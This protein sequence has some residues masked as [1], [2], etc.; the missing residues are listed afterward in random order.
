MIKAI[1]TKEEEHIAAIPEGEKE[2]VRQIF[3]NKGFSGETL[4]KIVDVITSD[5]ALWVDTMLQDEYGV[6]TAT[7]S[8]F[9]SG[10][11]TFVA[12]IAIGLLPLLPFMVPGFDKAI[13]FPTSCIIAVL[14]FFGVGLF[15]GMVL[16]QSLIKNGLSTLA[17]GVAAAL[18]AYI[19][20]EMA[21]QWATTA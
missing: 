17:M 19:I 12:F 16:G 1:R 13:V 15:K 9:R 4:E 11:A 14:A 6:Q 18:L 20:G 7:P 21:N 5:R 3:A 10:V 8:S 2:E